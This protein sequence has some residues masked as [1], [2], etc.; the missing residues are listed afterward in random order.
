MPNHSF[1]PK[2]CGGGGDSRTTL[3][4]GG[5]VRTAIV[6]PVEADD[7]DRA[8]RVDGA[9]DQIHVQSQEP[10]PGLEFT[11]KFTGA[12]DESVGRS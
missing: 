6:L 12:A 11:E 9:G 3:G 7:V 8:Q 4:C 2:D 5:D 10:N 1:R